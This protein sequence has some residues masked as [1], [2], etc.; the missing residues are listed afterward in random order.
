VVAVSGR[1]LANAIRDWGDR[2]RHLWFTGT[3]E[4]VEFD[5][6]SGTKQV[7]GLWVRDGEEVISCD[8]TD[9]IET[10]AVAADVRGRNVY[11][12]AAG[13]WLAVDLYKIGDR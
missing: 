7:R 12:V 2:S 1:D 5:T 6:T 13:A 3:V 11:V 10:A 4:R 9:R 8:F